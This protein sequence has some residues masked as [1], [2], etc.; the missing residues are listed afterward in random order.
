QLYSEQE[1]RFLADRYV[2]G[3]CPKCGHDSA[4]GDECTACGLSF[5][6]TDLLHPR[7]KLTGSPLVLKETKHWFLR[8]DLFKEK[9]L[10]WL[11]KKNWKTNVVNF[12]KSYIQDLRPRA[13]TRDMSWGIPV[14]LDSAKGKVLYVWF[15]APIGYISATKE[16]ALTQGTP[17]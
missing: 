11:S 3:T 14:P 5:D 16:W 7:S 6:A 12:I 10:D 2:V 9:L 13:I 15:D 8:L 17:D 1:G 4:R